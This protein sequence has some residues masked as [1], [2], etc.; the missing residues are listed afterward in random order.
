VAKGG[1]H[2]PCKGEL[3]TTT[4]TPLDHL[5]R[6]VGEIYEVSGSTDDAVGAVV[7]RVLDEADE[8]LTD[9]LLREGA[10]NL[11]GNLRYKTRLVIQGKQ[12]SPAPK[13][14]T[15]EYQEEVVSRLGK[16][17]DWPMMDGTRLKD[18]TREHVVKDA[19]RYA[20]IARGCDKNS[21]FLFG[22]AERMRPGQVAGRVVT[23][24]EM[25]EIM[26][27]VSGK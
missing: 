5:Q 14:F 4:D 27:Q 6:I 11:L 13:T 9:A 2:L 26:R 20:S 24:E 15:A 23:Q 3:V 12:K 16:Y 7:E 19:E 8:V 22:V 21:R 10:R 17:F 18:A 25:A 1:N